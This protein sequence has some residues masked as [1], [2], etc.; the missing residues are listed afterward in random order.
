MR[1]VHFQLISEVVEFFILLVKLAEVSCPLLLIKEVHLVIV[2]LNHFEFFVGL[3]LSQLTQLG[4]SIGVQPASA[5][6]ALEL[7]QVSIVS[8]AGIIQLSVR[9][10]KF[11]TIGVLVI[12]YVLDLTPWSLVTVDAGSLALADSP[13]DLREFSGFDL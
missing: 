2:V 12:D 7:G 3:V 10:I 9:I 5:H 1:H 4:K 13:V 8:L 11:F 6:H